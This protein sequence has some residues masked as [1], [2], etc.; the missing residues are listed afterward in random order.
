MMSLTASCDQNNMQLNLISD[1]PYYAT[2]NNL[3]G[4]EVYDDIIHHCLCNDLCMTILVH[5]HTSSGAHTQE[6]LHVPTRGAGAYGPVVL[7]N[8][9]VG[10]CEAPPV[11]PQL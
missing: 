4:R 1:V 2:F 8:A 6:S 10:V 11:G 5:Q 3:L 9:C 7:C